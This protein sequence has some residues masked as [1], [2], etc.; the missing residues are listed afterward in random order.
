MSSSPAQPLRELGSDEIEGYR[1]DGC[2]MARGLMADEWFEQIERAV[3]KVMAAPTPI[4][5]VFS[6]PKAGFHME[7]GLFITDDD[8]R[9]VVYRSPMARLAQNL[10]NS[11]KVHFFYDQMFCKTAGNQHPTPWHHDLTFWPVDGDQV[12]SIWIPLDPVSKESS[13][14]EFVRGSH[15]WPHRYKAITPMYNEQMVDPKH[16]DVPDIEANRADYDIVGFEMEP[17]D[18]LFFHP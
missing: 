18:M 14:L 2:L 8:I 3:A 16:E 12:V 1:R 7:A 5:A 9:E 15:L 17:G 13:G 6:D 11:Q 4:S 10:M